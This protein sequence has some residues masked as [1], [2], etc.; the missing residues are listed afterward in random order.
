MNLSTTYMG[1]RLKNPLVVASCSLTKSIDGIRGLAEG[2]A[3]A[4]VLKSLF[5]EQI[6]KEVVEDMERHL[7]PSWHYEAH[8][9]VNKM[10][11]EIGPKEYLKL[12]E[13]AKK[14]VPLPI[15]ASLNCVSSPWWLEYAKQIEDAGADALELN[16]A[17]LPSD[18]KRGADE[19]ERLY[20]RIVNKVKETISL[21]IAVKI[22]PHFTSL[23]RFTYELCS[24]GASALVLFNRFY[25]FDIDI[26][27]LRI[28]AGNP[29]S[30]SR[31]MNLVLRWIALLYGRIN[32]DLAATTGIHSGKEVIK[33]LLAGAQVVQ[34][35]SVLYERGS[36]YMNQMLDEVNRWMDSKGFKSV[37]EMRGR[38]SQKES[39]DPE[40]YER[41]QYIKAIV[42]I[43]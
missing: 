35:S 43:E 11:M 37:D 13:D 28:V 4:V 30:H 1:L 34:V 26:E 8:D 3:G 21:P 36:Q 9:Y 42:G 29:L 39:D 18:R 20:F 17:Y 2:G 14:S 19:V 16:I 33:Q 10:G 6:Q 25:Q 32:C 7:T 40:L 31:E 15:I 38:L 24:Q 27:R 41:L 5:E 23:S 12:I 22:G